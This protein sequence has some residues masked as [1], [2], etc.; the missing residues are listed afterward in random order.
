MAWVIGQGWS[1]Q[2]EAQAWSKHGPVIPQQSARKW[3]SADGGLRPRRPS[4]RQQLLRS[5]GGRVAWSDREG[6]CA[7]QACFETLSRMVGMVPAGISERGQQQ[8]NALCVELAFRPPCRREAHDCPSVVYCLLEVGSGGQKVSIAALFCSMMPYVRKCIVQRCVRRQRYA[9]GRIK[10]CVCA[11]R[12]PKRL[13]A[14][15]LLPP[16]PCTSTAC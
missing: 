13:V 12:C 4:L 8:T 1:C 3:P 10:S 16:L 11:T 6:A 14:H 7:P 9:Q 15:L 5:D 2:C